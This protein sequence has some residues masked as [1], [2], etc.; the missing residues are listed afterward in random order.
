MKVF[1]LCCL[2]FI[3]GSIISFVVLSISLNLRNVG[4]MIIDPSRPKSEMITRIVMS[5]DYYDIDW[6]DVEQIILTVKKLVE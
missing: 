5:D 2:C 3:I 6:D 1:L 4:T